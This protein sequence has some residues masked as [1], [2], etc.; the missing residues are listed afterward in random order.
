MSYVSKNLMQ[1][2]KVVYRGK[3]HWFVLLPGLI[4]VTFSG[5]LILLRSQLASAILNSG[6]Y[7]INS[8]A[9]TGFFFVGAILLLIPSLY[10]LAKDLL[11]RLTTE[12]AITN[13]RIIA[14]FGFIKRYTTELNHSKVE[15]LN[16]SQ[17]IIDRLLDSGTIIVNGTG[18][19]ATPIPKIDDPLAFRLKAMEAVDEYYRR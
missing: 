11:Y 7:D 16:V 5:L 2:E 18:K 12:L 9:L 13:K 19:E 3:I 15:S 10:R 1:G 6:N 14:K 17:S 4:G 8:K